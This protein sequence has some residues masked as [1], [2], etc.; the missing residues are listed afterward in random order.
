MYD[1]AAGRLSEKL[2]LFLKCN[3]NSDRKLEILYRKYRNI[4]L[5]SIENKY[6]KDN[7]LHTI[8]Y[9]YMWRVYKENT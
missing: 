3:I 6:K 5:I 7:S 1:T 9:D 4:L 2:G 8:K